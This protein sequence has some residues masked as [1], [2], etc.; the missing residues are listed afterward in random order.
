MRKFGGRWNKRRGEKKKQKE[1]KQRWLTLDWMVVLPPSPVARSLLG[2]QD[3]HATMYSDSANMSVTSNQRLPADNT[4]HLNLMYD[5]KPSPPL[6]PWGKTPIPPW[7]DS[8]LYHQIFYLA[9]KIFVLFSFCPIFVVICE[10]FSTVPHTSQAKRKA[11]QL[12]LLTTVWGVP[13][14]RHHWCS[15]SLYLEIDYTT[16]SRERTQAKVS[17]PKVTGSQISQPCAI[18]LSTFFSVFGLSGY[19][20]EP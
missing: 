17:P 6:P 20:H 10:Q 11:S 15:L 13:G 7:E 16:S 4:N 8:T 18:F 1:K 9:G 14:R 3:L 19:E 2:F 5:C 12:T